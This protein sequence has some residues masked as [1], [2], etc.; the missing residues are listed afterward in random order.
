MKKNRKHIRN[1]TIGGLGFFGGPKT[2]SS[3]CSTSPS[4]CMYRVHP[5]HDIYE[6]DGKIYL[7][8]VVIENMAIIAKE[9]Y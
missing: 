2:Y 1:I 4:S 5:H 3:E 6:E 9:Y 7:D 8:G